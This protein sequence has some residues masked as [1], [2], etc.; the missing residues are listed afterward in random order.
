[1]TKKKY[2]E[3]FNTVYEVDIV[4]ANMNVTLKDLQKTYTY[5]DGVELDDEMLQS[6]ATTARCKNKLTNRY[7]VVV[8]YNKPSSIKGIDKRADLINTAAHEALHTAM[9]LYSFIGEDV[10][11]NDSNE[12]LAYLV[13]WITEKIY[14]VWTK[15]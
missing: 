15:K 14:Q 7:C 1:M 11:P 5:S 6:M 13:G 2:I 12:N 10:R 4:I 9:D 3:T 8:K